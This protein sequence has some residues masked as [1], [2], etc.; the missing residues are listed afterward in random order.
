[1]PILVI[2]SSSTG[3][4][5]EGRR[6]SRRKSLYHTNGLEINGLVSH[7]AFER[8]SPMH[9][10]QSAH[11]CEGEGA[12]K[13]HSEIHDSSAHSDSDVHARLRP[14]SAMQLPSVTYTDLSSCET[15]IEHRQNVERVLHPAPPPT[16]KNSGTW[17]HYIA[18][19]H[20]TGY[21]STGTNS[22]SPRR[23]IP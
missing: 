23:S 22:G 11:R 15:L 20:E 4:E 16:L 9:D 3:I 21:S 6:H 2:L 1:V 8:R 14:S 10:V 19:G 5:P 7:E 13:S 12:R 18:R 17:R